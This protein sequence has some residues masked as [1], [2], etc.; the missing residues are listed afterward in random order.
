[1]MSS[2]I[3]LP[4]AFA[5]LLSPAASKCVPGKVDSVEF[6][7]N[8]SLLWSEASNPDGCGITTYVI[9]IVDVSDDTLQMYTTQ[10]ATRSYYFNSLAMC[11]NYSFEVHALTNESVVGPADSYLLRTEPKANLNLSVAFDNITVESSS[12]TLSWSQLSADVASCV[13]SYRL[14]Y[15]DDDDNPTDVYVYNNSY[16]IPNVTPCMTYEFQ[17]RAILG[18]PEAEGPFSLSEKAS[19]GEVPSPPK[20]SSIATNSTTATMTWQLDSYSTNRCE[21]QYLAVNT[22]GFANGTFTVPVNDTSARAPVTFTIAGLAPDTV[23]ISEVAVVNSAGPSKN[24][25][26]TYQTADDVL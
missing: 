23:Y 7:S 5:I 8:Y 21:I 19:Y 20:L 22:V 4:L 26:I 10:A 16:T 18:S 13:S 12:I 14:V 1:M 6:A 9:Y 15:W 25:T 24:V 11:A 3:W 17:V 2:L